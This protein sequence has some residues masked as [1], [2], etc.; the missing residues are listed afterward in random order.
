[1]ERFFKYF[2]KYAKAML[3][4]GMV[5]A[6]IYAFYNTIGT[7]VFERMYFN[8]FKIPH[9]DMGVINSIQLYSTITDKINKVLYF[10]ILLIPFSFV[11]KKEQK[12]FAAAKA[13]FVLILGF[14]A[15]YVF[16]FIFDHRSAF[17][18]PQDAFITDLIYYGTLAL[19]ETCYYGALFATGFVLLKTPQKK[20][21]RSVFFCAAPFAVLWFLRRFN[22]YYHI[23]NS[24]TG[25]DVLAYYS[26]QTRITH[27]IEVLFCVY[28]VALVAVLFLKRKVKP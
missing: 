4:I 23:A 6:I 21:Q 26:V 15:L 9:G 20:L 13:V 22:V 11:V 12:N 7:Y 3:I 14:F 28:L 8:N 18:L 2:E 1:V 17:G 25:N 19:R 10:L 16:Y 27:I 24:I 5:A